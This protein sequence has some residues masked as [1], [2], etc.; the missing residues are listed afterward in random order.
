M[1]KLFTIEALVRLGMVLLLLLSIFVF[2]KIGP[3]WHPILDVIQTIFVPFFVAIFITYLLHP[4][5]EWLH[6]KG[7]PRSI[8]ILIIYLTFFGGTGFLIFKSIPYLIEQLKGLSEQL[9]VLSDTYKIWVRE[10]YERTDNLPE[11]VHKEFEETLHATERYLDGMIEGVI[12]TIKVFWSNIFA[13]IVIPFLVF[14]MLKDIDV[15]YKMIG[16]I[17]P[18]KWREPGKRL[19]RDV[20]QSL[21]N[22]IRGQL[23]VAVALS[24]IAIL[25]FWLAGVPYPVILG[26]IIGVTDFIPYFGPIIGAIPVALIAAT[27]SVNKLLIVLGILI[28]LQFIE[29]NILGPLI[30]GKTLH[31]H[32]IMI[33]FALLVGGEIGGVVGLL[34]AVPIFAVGK[35]IF[36]HTRK[37]FR[38]VDNE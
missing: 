29:G 16:N 24:L 27:I 31:I 5:V 12:E 19:A 28:V 18:K 2:M 15:I 8:A 25:A 6:R 35:V 11:V 4:I 32:P 17:T 34:L 1:K 36:L 9:P 23:T 7:L 26:L 14:Y 37:H 33:I 38:N 21:G 3:F 20:D 13:W 10:F 30:V 22:Y